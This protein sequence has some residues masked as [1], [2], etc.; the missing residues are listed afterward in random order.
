MF[1]EARRANFKEDKKDEH[2]GVK[3]TGLIGDAMTESV[4]LAHTLAKNYLHKNLANTAA[5]KYLE[6]YNLHLHAPE[7]AVPKVMIFV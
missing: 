3:I 7:G 2:G 4:K 1:L 5:A 6:T